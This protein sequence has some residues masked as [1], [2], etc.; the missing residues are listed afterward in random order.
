MIDLE[1]LGNSSNSVI[2]SIGAAAFNDDE[3]THK[4]YCV[5]DPQSCINAGMQMDASTVMWWL[6]QSQDARDAIAKQPETNV[7]IYIALERFS[8]WFPADAQVWGN[9]ATFDNV[10]LDNA[11]RKTGVVRPWKFWNDR[12][13]RTLKNLY[14]AIKADPFEGTAHNALA[15]ACHQANHAIKILKA[16]R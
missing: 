9:G 3:I 10:I 6:Q 14:P 5:V 7:P 4:F 16:I 1:T 8:N 11:Y 15:D 13:Y 12:C 2:V